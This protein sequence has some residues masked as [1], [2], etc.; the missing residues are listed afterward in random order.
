MPC[1]CSLKN[2]ETNLDSNLDSNQVCHR[3]TLKNVD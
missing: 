1:S 2:L 3:P